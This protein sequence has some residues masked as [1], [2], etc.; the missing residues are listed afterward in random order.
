MAMPDGELFDIIEADVRCELWG[1]FVQDI[2][3]M[4]KVVREGK[5]LSRA[6]A[7]DAYYAMKGSALLGVMQTGHS[8][9][10]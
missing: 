10:R 3:D 2:Q 5:V 7:W 9:W 4:R 1:E 8:G 6:C